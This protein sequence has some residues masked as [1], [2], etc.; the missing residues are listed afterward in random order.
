MFI[1]LPSSPVTAP[2]LT[3]DERKLAVERL[4][5]NQTG[6]ENKTFKMYQ[7][8]EAI[9]DYKF[10]LFFLLGLFGKQPTARL[11]PGLRAVRSAQFERRERG[12]TCLPARKDGEDG[13]RV[14]GKLTGN[15]KHPQRRNQQLFKYPV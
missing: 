1:L 2:L 5:A 13:A 12:Q 15:S 10:Y 11:V 14:N 8:Q 7:A 3:P 4:R 6:V 9:A